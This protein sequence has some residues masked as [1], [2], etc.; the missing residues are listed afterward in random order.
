MLSTIL[1]RQAKAL[2]KQTKLTHAQS[3]TLLA[4]TYRCVDYHE[5]Q[6][7]IKLQ[8]VDERLN[9]A[10]LNPSSFPGSVDNWESSLEYQQAVL[11]KELNLSSQ[12]AV[13]LSAK[14]HGFNNREDIHYQTLD[15]LI[16]SDEVFYQI[17]NQLGEELSGDIAGTNASGFMIDDYNI[18]TC[19][20]EA[21]SELYVVTL[22]I[23]YTGEQDPDRPWCGD[24]FHPRVNVYFEQMDNQWCYESLALNTE[25]NGD[26]VNS[27]E[28]EDLM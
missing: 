16:S 6:R 21:D 28:Y 14:L 3:Q 2:K 8:Q 26:D 18:L 1:K 17:D 4:R 22:D 19:D 7:L 10:S 13:Q 5:L 9:G 20:A 27:W 15:D 25:S 23:T 24:Q 12:D 11:T